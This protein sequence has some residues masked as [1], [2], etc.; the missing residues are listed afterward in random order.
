[1]AQGEKRASSGGVLWQLYHS[2]T[3]KDKKKS[4]EQG[5]KRRWVEQPR[6]LGQGHEG[7]VAGVAAA[8]D[9]GRNSFTSLFIC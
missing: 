2:A 9:D 3:D 4:N 6:I 8:G 1:M 7:S 5:L